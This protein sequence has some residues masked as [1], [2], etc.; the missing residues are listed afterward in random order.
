MHGVGVGGRVHGDGSDAELLA[1]ALDAQC[2]LSPV[3]DQNFVEHVGQLS[4]QYAV[5]DYSIDAERRSYSM[6]TS[7]SPNSTGWPFSNR[8]AV[9]VPA[10]GAGIWFI[11]FMASM[12][13]SVSPCVTLR[14]TSMKAG[15]PGSGER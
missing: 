9:T 7:G 1:R 13:S 12:M 5:S 3:G 11:V 2:N 6:M 10:C 8:I 4:R 14:P 15:A